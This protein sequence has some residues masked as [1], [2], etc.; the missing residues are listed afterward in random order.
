MAKIKYSAIV[1]SLGQNCDRFLREGYKYPEE[2]KGSFQE[3][4]DALAGLG[5]LDALDL[6]YAEE[7]INSD[8]NA[9][10]ELMDKYGMVIS[11]T[12]PNLF[13][14]RRW[15]N[16]SLTHPD[17]AVRE[18]AINLCK[19]AMDFNAGLKGD[20]PVNLWLGQDG[21]DYPL[22][23]D[24]MKQFE[25]LADAIRQLADYRPDVRITLEGKVREPRNRC[26]IDTVSR[27]LLYCKEVDRPNVGLAIDIG[28]VWQAQQN[29]A[30]T[31]ALA[32]KMGKLWTMHVNDNYNMWDDDMIAGTVRHM[33][34]IEMFYYLKKYEYDGYMAVDIFPYRDDTLG[35][36]KETVLNL[37]KFES[38]VDVI[39]MDNLTE[40]IA[41]GDAPRMSKLI[42]ESIYK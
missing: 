3:E 13:G 22:Q 4:V 32:A 26:V 30:Q 36:T 37:K 25:Y 40:V 16:G 20:A 9:V 18:E 28:H 38:L 10:N 35:C 14:E 5:V 27:A 6:Y 8:P 19:K 7:G 31:I 11:S 17:P 29:V 24:Y 39:G 23:V 21:F 41:S 1:G 33:E 12:F 34:Y 2:I 42:R 15:Q